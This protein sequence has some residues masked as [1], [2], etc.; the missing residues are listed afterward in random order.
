[1]NTSLHNP[2]L[3]PDGLPAFSRIRPEDIVP[4]V[5]RSLEKA[6]ATIADLLESVAPS[7]RGAGMFDRLIPPLE[8]LD[9]SLNRIWSPVS[10]L[11]SVADN[12]ELREAHNACLPMLSEYS[13]EFG[14]NERLFRALEHIAESD[15]IARLSPTKRKILENSLQD[16]RL[17]GVA[18]NAGDK[19]RFKAISV[20]LAT[21]K[22]KFSEN[23]LDAT[24][25]WKKQLLQSEAL[26][27]LPE[28]ALAAA[29]QAAEREGRDGFLLTLEFPCYLAVITFADDP[30]LRREIYEAYTTRGSDQGPDAGQWDNTEIMEEILALR[31]EKARLLG[32][33]SYAECSLV[34]KMAPS[35]EHVLDFIRDLARRTRQM[36]EREFQELRAFARKRTGLSRL[37]SWDIPYYSEKLSQ[38]KFSFSQED[39]RAYFPAPKVLSGLFEIV[40]RLFE[41]RIDSIGDKE[42]WHPDVR[43]HEVR[44]GDGTPVGGFFLDLYARPHKRSGAWM[45]ECITRKALGGDIQRPVAYL[46]CNFGP[47]IG[48]KPSLLTHEEVLTLFHE[49]G[50]ALHHLLTRMDYPSIAGTNG[51]AWDAVELPSQLLEQWCWER[52]ALRY[53]SGHVDTGAPL[54]D[55]LLD[56]L[57]AS[58]NFQSGMAMV[59]Q[60]EYALFDFRIHRE[61]DHSRREAG[62]ARIQRLLREVRD[63]VAVVTP[64]AFY[65]MAHSFSH[66]FAGGYAAG[67]YSYKWAEMLAS[68]AFAKFE[69]N[70]IFDGDTGSLF[71]RTILEQ[72]GSR[73]AMD[74]FKEFRGREPD[75]DA[76]LRHSGIEGESVAIDKTLPIVSD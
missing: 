64:P 17:S 56:S 70:G 37:E 65:R 28:S 16:F 15:E 18:L 13:T 2:W 6:R 41:L 59:R 20:R 30:S 75:I 29:R 39:L 66:I 53:I 38:Q 73:D 62:G 34:K 71:R 68:D 27:G 33:S 61:Y 45:D 47:P 54:P 11:H 23:I 31:D 42:A 8:G 14:Q 69:E 63:E 49:F 40:H 21:L 22:S 5:E 46:T 4:T 25:A 12:P 67:Y 32:F 43:F 24:G 72:G 3:N 52:E 51:V 58:R 19:A 55:M 44:D 74:L 60:L 36:A 57:R 50:H 10:H 76:L 48:D 26:S 9:D 1:M 35:P 7:A